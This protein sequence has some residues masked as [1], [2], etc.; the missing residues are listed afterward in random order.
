M[1][2]FNVAPPASLPQHN[3]NDAFRIAFVLPAGVVQ[4][5][6]LTVTLPPGLPDDSMPM[7]AKLWSN[8]T[9]ALPIAV[10]ITSH[11]RTTGVTVITLSGAG[12]AAG[13][14]LVIEYVSV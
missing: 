10:T 8:A 6:T 12:P 5:D 1:P 2:N 9:P 4:N 7:D 14:E 11:N 3:S 13:Q